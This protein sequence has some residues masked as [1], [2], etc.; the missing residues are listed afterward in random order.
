[1]MLQLDSRN[2]IDK[3]VAFKNC[4]L[5]IN[6]ISTINNTQV[7]NGENIGIVMPMYSLLEYSDS[8][9]KTSG[10]LWKYYRD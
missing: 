5:F 2:E 3:G 9:A 1:M 7:D 8:Y 10:S 4:A 6:C